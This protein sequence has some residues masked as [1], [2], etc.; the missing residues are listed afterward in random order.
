M[1]VRPKKPRSNK[2]DKYDIT[3]PIN[4][5]VTPPPPPPKLKK[6][7]IV[8]TACQGKSTLIKDMIAR[9]PQLSSPEKSY[10]DVIREK[11]LV[12]NKDGN[13][14]S[15]M[16]ILNVLVD[17]IMATYEGKKIVFDRCPLDNLIYTLW[18]NAKHPER[19]SDKAVE[20]TIDIVRE[21]L[22]MLD[23]IFFIPITSTHKVPIVPSE[24]RAVD[25]EYIEEIDNLFKAVI[26]TQKLGVGKFFPVE[27]C[28]PVIEVFGDRETRIKMLELYINSDCEFVGGDESVMNELAQS[29]QVGYDNIVIK[30]TK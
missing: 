21:S 11:G 5:P 24:Q 30:P 14:E 15:Q 4:Q 7:A 12:I 6:I 13:E 3:N 22:K 26:R 20:K 25:P 27:D 28:P 8:G 19:M 18:L 23:A 2:Y 29:D 10:R 1:P 9:W 17:Q 16:V